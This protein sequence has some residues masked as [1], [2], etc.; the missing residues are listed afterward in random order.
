MRNVLKDI[1]DSPNM[2]TRRPVVNG[3]FE[4]NI[5]GLYIIGDRAGAQVVKLAMEQGHDVAHTIARELNGTR[6]SA[7]YDLIVNLDVP[8]EQRERVCHRL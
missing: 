7:A 3:K 8:G 4:S 1:L 5:R 2:P 6:G